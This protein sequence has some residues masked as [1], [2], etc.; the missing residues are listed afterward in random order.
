MSKHENK[1]LGSRGEK[2]AEQYLAK[3]GYRILARNF[4]TD[5]GEID[6]VATD[7]EYLVFAE[8]KTRMSNEFGTPAEAVDAHKQRKLS[9]VAAQY[10]KKTMLYGAPARFDVVEIRLDTGDVNH[11]I[12]AFDSYLGY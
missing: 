5:I 6:L 1:Y 7:D 10:I 11:I 2:I 8:V 4:T 9:M 3:R 12:N